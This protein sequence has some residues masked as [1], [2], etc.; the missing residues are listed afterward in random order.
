MSSIPPRSGI[1]SSNDTDDVLLT[2]VCDERWIEAVHEA[3]H[4]IVARA[5]GYTL[6]EVGIEDGR[7]RCRVRT[8]PEGYDEVRDALFTLAG[9]KAEN[10][11]LGTIGETSLSDIDRKLFRSL[12]PGSVD[13]EDR[14]AWCRTVERD[15]EKLVAKERDTIQA[16]A[17][18]LVRL[19][20]RL[21]GPE[22]R[23]IVDSVRGAST[24]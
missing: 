18:R 24:E 15:I 11:I 9:E 10:E 20:Y 21:A 2:V 14:A 4:A 16:V 6:L 17:M 12:G 22:V 5:V 19:P 7:F 3:G 13:S 1:V 23:A 8:D